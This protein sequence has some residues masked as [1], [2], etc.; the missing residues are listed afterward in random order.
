MLSLAAVGLWSSIAAGVL[1]N[2]W[3]LQDWRIVGALGVVLVVSAIVTTVIAVRANGATKPS[4]PVHI[5]AR[6]VVVNTIGDGTTVTTGDVT[7]T[8]TYSRPP[9][10]LYDSLGRANLLDRAKRL[11]DARR[12]RRLA[13]TG[14][15]KRAAEKLAAKFTPTAVVPIP[16]P[17]EILVLQGELG[18]GKSEAAEGALRSAVDRAESVGA[19]SIP[20]WVSVLDLTSVTSLEGYVADQ[21]G[22]EHLHKT[23]VFVVLDGL[24]ERYHEI[25]TMLTQASAFVAA[26]PRSRILIT[27]RPS[28]FTDGFDVRTIA[29]LT[30]N[31]ALDLIRTVIHPPEY[32]DQDWNKDFRELICRPL[33]ALIAA[34]HLSKLG[35]WTSAAQLIDLV[36][37]ESAKREGEAF[38]SALRKIAVAT[39]TAGGPVDL[40]P[41]L[42]ADELDSVQRSPLLTIDGHIGRFM[43]AAFQ[44]WIAAQAIVSGEVS[45]TA[46]TSSMVTFDRWRYAISIAITAAPPEQMDTLI[47]DIARWRPAAASWV[48]KEIKRSRFHPPQQVSND[49]AQDTATHRVR[50]AFDAW[51]DGLGPACAAFDLDGSEL[52]PGS[53]PLDWVVTEAEIDGSADIVTIQV[54]TET[55]HLTYRR[56]ITHFAWPWTVVLEI[57]ADR[58]GRNLTNY[59]VYAIPEGVAETEIYRTLLEKVPD[60]PTREQLQKM[61][62]VLDSKIPPNSPSTEHPLNRE[63]LQILLRRMDAADSDTCRWPGPDQ[64][65][66]TPWNPVGGYSLTRLGE[67][68]QAILTAAMVSY[69]EIVDALFPK[70][71]DTLHTRLLMP[72]TMEGD[73]TVHRDSWGQSNHEV[74]LTSW[75]R[76]GGT[77][78][79]VDVTVESDNAAVRMHD[80]DDLLYDHF[81]EWLNSHPEVRAFAYYVRSSG[82][83]ELFGQAPASAL[84][85]KWLWDDLKR[86]GFV[87][88]ISAPKLL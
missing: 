55:R 2:L 9:L 71:K 88:G 81:R 82:A 32:F 59:I 54:T 66:P 29:P 75:M 67:R 34:Q 3:W 31:E 83:T 61:I 57:I 85:W 25:P 86:A 72:A 51:L 69:Q 58:L 77:E 43:L 53:S 19:E 62:S 33:F 21:I 23:G 49:I 50:A 84:A 63:D 20:I 42:S 87:D 41:Q 68:A 74:W 60:R 22:T 17:G 11:S 4:E 15:S 56:P 10:N 16:A 30:E 26:W 12:L 35:A 64:D 46:I 24:D 8:I 6:A 28:M 48:L 80:S 65:N 45:N 70:F 27:A 36:V 13:A 73:L 78:N 14:L 7:N 52:R 40:R 44:Q 18:A 1:P 76:P 47:G 79:R 5:G 38:S 39:T 37:A